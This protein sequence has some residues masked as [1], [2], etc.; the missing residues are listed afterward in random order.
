LTLADTGVINKYIVCVTLN[1]IRFYKLSH[2]KKRGKPRKEPLNTVMRKK[3]LQ[4]K[5]K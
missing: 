3:G 5:R 4:G 2:G 1:A